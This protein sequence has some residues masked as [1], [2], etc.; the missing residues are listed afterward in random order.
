MLQTLKSYLNWFDLDWFRYSTFQSY[1][2]IEPLFLYFIPAVPFLFLLRWLIHFRFRKKLEIAFFEGKA[3]WHW[4]SILRY[5][6][7]IYFALFIIFVLVALARPQLTNERV[8]QYSEGIDITLVLDVSGSMELKDFKPNRLEAAKEVARNFIQGRS[9]DRIGL[10]VFA[11]DAY[12]LT[13]LTTD[14]DL[15]R[16]SINDVQLGMI[17]NDGTS[18]GSALGVAINRMRES[19]GKSKVCILI[20]DGENTGGNI[21]PATAAKLAYGFNIKIYTIGIGKD[22][23]IPYTDETGKTS[24]IQTRL[25]ETNLR[26]IAKAASGTF[27]RASDKKALNAIFSRINRLEKA[28]IQESRFRDTRDYYQVYLTWAIICFLLWLVI[29]NTFLANALED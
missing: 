14:Y 29:K 21:D 6:P 18:I 1:D 25:D 22:G 15:L 4:S 27:F 11:G 3:I 5:I 16:E 8:E 9:H 20:S 24:Y 13:P 23:Q 12:S 10:V 7:D 28:K 26:E 2:W 17:A 19:E